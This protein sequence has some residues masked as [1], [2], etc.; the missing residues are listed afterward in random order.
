MCEKGA[1]MSENSTVEPEEQTATSKPAAKKRKN[2][3]LIILPIV[4]VIVVAAVGLWVWHEQPSFCNAICH[5]PMDPYYDTY[6]QEPGQSGV[7]KWGNS[8]E[9]TSG[10]MSVTHKAEG[11]ACM[12]CHVP[13][14]NEQIGEAGAWITGNYEVVDNSTYDGVLKE[15]SLSK[16]VAERNISSDEFCLNAGCHNVTRVDLVEL[17]AGPMAN[18]HL[19]PHG[20]YECSECH[21]AHRAS[22]NACTACHSDSPVPEGWL[23]VN[24]EKYLPAQAA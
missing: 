15:V 12:G 7:D 19:Q 2:K 10:M 23:S 5:M 18:P 3:L 1:D 6:A 14:L 17:T 4:A 22:V 9:N 16:L 8:V 11:I 13:T 21:K 24:Q 20:E